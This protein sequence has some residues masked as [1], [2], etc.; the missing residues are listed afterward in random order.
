MRRRL[1]LLLAPWL[2]VVATT[3]AAAADP[4]ALVVYGAADL[5]FAFKEVVLRF[6]KALGVKVTLV[7]GSTGNLARQIEHGAPADV[8]FA[9]DQ[10]VVDDLVARGVVIPATRTVYAR[11][12][13]V[14]ATARS[15]GPKLT[16]LR[17]LLEARVRRVAIANP[18]HAPYGRA[19]EE[20]L[21]ATGIWQAVKPKLVYAENVRQAL[22]FVQ[23]GA[24]DAGIV[25]LAVANVPE[26]DW[27]A[28]DAALH[29]PIHQ[30]A[31]VLRRSPR[32]E[33]GLAFIQFVNGP[34]GRPIMKRHGFVLPGEF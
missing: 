34:E 24:A 22:Q 27:V 19:A 23:T 21:R 17:G 5:A 7:L 12:R 10:S 25:A 31:G 15:A 33:A 9:A 1:F 8:F 6:E 18:L 2:A 11:G 16:E 4:P 30:A 3:P 20:A 28:V 29:S 13:L 32:P 26:I 14:L